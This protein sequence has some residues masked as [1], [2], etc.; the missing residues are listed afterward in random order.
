MGK[1]P[2]ADELRSQQEPAKHSPERSQRLG[3]I[4]QDLAPEL[5]ERY[6]LMDQIG[7]IITRVAPG[8]EAAEKG[9]RAGYIIKEVNRRPV[10]NVTEFKDAVAGAAAKGRALLLVSDGQASQYVVLKVPRD[11]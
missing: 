11:G 9:L 10:S 1:R 5:A 7:V 3:L 2:S 4:V 8:T 6:K